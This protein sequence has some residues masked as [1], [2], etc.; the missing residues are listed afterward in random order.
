MGKDLTKN[1]FLLGFFETFLTLDEDEE[2]E[3]LKEI[4][5]LPAE[6]SEQVMNMLN[7]W[8]EKGKKEGEWKGKRKVASKLLEEG[9][10]IELISALTELED[11]EM[12]EIKLLNKNESAQV[13]KL[14]NSYREKGEKEGEQESRKKVAHNMLKEGISLELIT[15]FMNLEYAE[16]EELSKLS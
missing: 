14:P 12:E 16:I 9:M 7:N 6:E 13:L 2:N 10:P 15:K 4:K 5:K 8:I 3:L 11:A 1:E